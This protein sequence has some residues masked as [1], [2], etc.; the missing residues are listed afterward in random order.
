MTQ[1]TSSHVKIRVIPAGV[2][3]HQAESAA[4][5]IRGIVADIGILSSEGVARGQ[6]QVGGGVAHF[7]PCLVARL[8]FFACGR[9]YRQGGAAE[10][11]AHQVG[12][13]HV[14]VGDGVG[15]HGD[16]G[17]AG[18]VVLGDLVAVLDLVMRAHEEGG[19]S[20]H[21]GL[22][23]LSVRVVGELRHHGFSCVADRGVID[24]LADL[25]QAVFRVVAQGVVLEGGPFEDVT[26]N[27]IAVGVVGVWRAGR[28]CP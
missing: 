18:Q 12:Q 24:I 7:A 23:A 20:V 19:L 1:M 28:G 22:D 27:H 25:H 5:Q 10:V 2:V 16:A 26:R 8:D 15:A 21:D 9:I 14:V 3:E 13:G 17:R 6:G 11:V 4:A